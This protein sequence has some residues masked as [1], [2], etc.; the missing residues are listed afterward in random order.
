[1]FNIYTWPN[2]ST[3]LKMK[4]TQ[5]EWAFHVFQVVLKATQVHLK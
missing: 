2:Y 5:L 1:M 4:L 3:I